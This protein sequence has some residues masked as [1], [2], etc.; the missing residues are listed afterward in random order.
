MT[1]ND[2]RRVILTFS[3]RLNYRFGAFAKLSTEQK[4]IRIVLWPRT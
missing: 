2:L 3:D 1:L 4:E